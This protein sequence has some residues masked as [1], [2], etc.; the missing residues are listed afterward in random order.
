MTLGADI[1]AS[2]LA[3][4]PACLPTYPP[5]PSPALYPKLWQAIDRMSCFVL[6]CTCRLAVLGLMLGLIVTAHAR[7]HS[8][9]KPHSTWP[10][11]PHNTEYKTLQPSHAGLRPLTT[12]QCIGACDKI[13]PRPGWSTPAHQAPPSRSWPGETWCFGSGWCMGAKAACGP[14][15]AATAPHLHAEY[16]RR[17]VHSPLIFHANLRRTTICE[18]SGWCPLVLHNAV[19]LR[20]ALAGC[21]KSPFWLVCR[22][23]AQQDILSIAWGKGRGGGGG[24]G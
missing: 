22:H 16:T 2:L 8:T 20:A 21:P 1:V 14:Q 19:L 7:S 10:Q 3:H 9:Q 5:P 23:H 17:L 13:V 4:L 24:G 18:C 11:K 12:S 15:P 6:R